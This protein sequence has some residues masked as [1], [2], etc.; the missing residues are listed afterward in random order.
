[1][2]AH[3]NQ[4]DLIVEDVPE[5]LPHVGAEVVHGV[6]DQTAEVVFAKVTGVVG[7]GRRT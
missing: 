7:I 1:M 5:L 3:S 2:S 4:P 6:A